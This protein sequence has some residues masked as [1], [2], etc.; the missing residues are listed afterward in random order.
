MSSSPRATVPGTRGRADMPSAKKSDG[1]RGS[2]LGWLA[3]FCLQEGRRQ[4][5]ESR[6]TQRT[7]LPSAFCLLISL[8]RDISHLPWMQRLQELPCLIQIEFR[9]PRLHDE[10][11]LVAR[12]LIESLEVEH[13]VIRHGQAVQGEHAEHRGERG[14][15][16]RALEGDGDPG[17]PRV[18]RLAA[19]ESG[20]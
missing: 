10:E 13:G 3:I 19:D 2:Y 16:D 7:P 17:R 9:I 20:R 8:P 6:R 11:E 4:R 15:E 14:E 12:G 5:A 1:S 18:V